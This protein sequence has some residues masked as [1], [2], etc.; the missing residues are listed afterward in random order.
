MRHRR[1]LQRLSSGRRIAVRALRDG[2]DIDSVAD[3]PPDRIVTVYRDERSGLM[4]RRSQRH[5]DAPRTTYVPHII[6]QKPFDVV[7][8]I[9]E[10]RRYVE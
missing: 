4:M 1:S 7:D 6:A 2:S 10:G 9:N 8:V 3:A 5:P